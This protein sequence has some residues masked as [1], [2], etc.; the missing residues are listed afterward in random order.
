M[1]ILSTNLTTGHQRGRQGEITQSKLH[2]NVSPKRHPNK[3]NKKRHT[4]NA[5]KKVIQKCSI[6]IASQKCSIKMSPKKLAQFG[7]W[8]MI[9]FALLAGSGL[10]CSPFSA[11]PDRD[12]KL[13]RTKQIG[14]I[15]QSANKLGPAVS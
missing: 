10:D 5:K 15:E 13:K 9:P 3:L 12:G 7:Q 14:K 8:L 1:N 2:P 6:R 11:P 4:N